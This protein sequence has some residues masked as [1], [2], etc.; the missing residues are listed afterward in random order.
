MIIY[1]NKPSML[2]DITQLCR[3]PQEI[4]AANMILVLHFIES[5]Y[6]FVRSGFLGKED[7]HLKFAP[8]NFKKSM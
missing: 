7:E 5:G 4:A 3:T 2:E 8:T 6:V 1:E